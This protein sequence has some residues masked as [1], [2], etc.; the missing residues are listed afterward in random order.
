MTKMNLFLLLRR[1]QIVQN[2]Q[3]KK[4]S[5]YPSN[6]FDVISLQFYVCYAVSAQPK[7]GSKLKKKN[8]SKIFL[9]LRAMNVL[10]EYLYFI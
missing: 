8:D 6:R 9:A 1:W 2:K 4:H 3:T 5:I 7:S 10:M